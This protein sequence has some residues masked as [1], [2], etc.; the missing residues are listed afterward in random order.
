MNLAGLIF[1]ILLFGLGMYIYLLAIGKVKFKS[2]DAAQKAEEFRQANK[3]WMRILSLA[4]MA[5]MAV[6]IYLHMVQG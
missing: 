6:E 4:L 1:E 2:G 3:G 5:L